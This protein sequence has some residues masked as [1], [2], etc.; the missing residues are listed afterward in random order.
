M[1]KLDNYIKKCF[2]DAF[3]TEDRQYN[4]KDW[5]YEYVVVNNELV[6]PISWCKYKKVQR[7][8]EYRI[9]NNIEKNF[10]LKIAEHG[11]GICKSSESCWLDP[12][13]TVAYL[14][15]NNIEYRMDVYSE[16][17][18]DNNSVPYIIMLD[19]L[20][21]RGISEDEFRK[22]SFEDYKKVWIEVFG[23]FHPE[24]KITDTS[25]NVTK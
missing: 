23:D 14:S 2:E 24:V 6:V 7:R 20:K 10:G 4:E 13:H 9:K 5:N 1:Q 22:Y 8:A 11:F 3:K 12:N 19:Y 17:K 16:F 18:D 15:I 21:E 25:E